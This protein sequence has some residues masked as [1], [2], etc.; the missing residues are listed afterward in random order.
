MALQFQP[1]LAKIVELL[2]YLAHK[3]P[4]ADKYQAVKFFYLADREH[5]ARY[6]RPITSERY[7]A[8]K[9]GPVASNAKD[10][11]EGDRF[12]MRKAGINE[13]P[14]EVKQVDR[15]GPDRA[16]LVV[17]GAPKR[18]IDRDLFSR[19]DLK[20][21]DEVLER[22]G[23]LDFD[24][25]FNLTHDHQAYKRAWARRGEAQRGEMTYDEMIDSD[26]KR[27]ALVSDIGPVSRHI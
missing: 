16:P 26:E 12:T 18:E 10:L 15:P 13:L 4:G 14:F 3:M 5:L 24:A 19:S 7:F 2:L 9:Y 11:L 22:H 1:N 27:A 8:L 21:F 25:L 23:N 20:V 6:G 17:I